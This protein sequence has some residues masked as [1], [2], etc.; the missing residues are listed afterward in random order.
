MYRTAAITEF[1][2]EMVIG[3]KREH[4][5][6]R[7]VFPNVVPDFRAPVTKSFGAKGHY[8]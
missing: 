3:A 1:G 5:S 4:I 8:E 2:K 6:G 7:S